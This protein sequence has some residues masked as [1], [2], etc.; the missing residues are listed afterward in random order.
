M[1]VVIIGAGLGGLSAACHLAGRGH[2]VVVVEKEDRAGGRVAALEANGYRLDYGPAVLTHVGILADVFAAARAELT[3]HLELIR[4]DPMYRATFPAGDDILVRADREAMTDEVASKCGPADAAAFGRFRDWVSNRCRV[5]T[6]ADV[7]RPLARPVRRLVRPLRMGEPERWQRVVDGS[8]ADP[9]LRQL[10]SFPAV[11]AGANPFEALALHSLVEGVAFPKGGMSSVGPALASA[12]E[13]A[14]VA[15]LYERTVERIGRG[16]SGTGPADGVWLTSGERVAADAVVCNA[17]LPAAY[18]T[19]LPGVDPPR[20]S[21]R[22]GY[23]PSCILWVAGVRGTLPGGAAHHNLHFGSDGRQAFDAIVR[24][25][26]RMAEPLTLV[27]GAS[28]SDS[29]LAPSGR[30]TLYVLEPTPNLSGNIDWAACTDRVQADL[31]AR[32]GGLG[33]PVDVEME[34]CFAP[35]GW[36]HLGLHQGTPFG[37][38]RPP[39]I[40]R[41]IPKLYFVGS[42]TLSG[43]ALPRVLLSG[44]WAADRVEGR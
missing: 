5:D 18:E 33:Y 2:E 1:R 40:E 24:R 3:H 41:R 9:R 31:V 26:T 28:V 6:P 42:S 13:K 27:T 20:A 34:R 17:D 32:A 38:L 21:R 37:P 19:L 43:A 30:S 15:L 16:P 25:G 23:S 11:Y 12:A 36:R 8:F 22:G 7:A 10:F 29:S 4:L 35:A 14:G 39:G 44:R